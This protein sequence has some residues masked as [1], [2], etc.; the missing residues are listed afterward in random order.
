MM[1]N[2]IQANVNLLGFNLLSTEQYQFYAYAPSNNYTIGDDQDLNIVWYK[3]EAFSQN[4]KAEIIE[5]FTVTKK[6]FTNSNNQYDHNQFTITGTVKIETASKQA[7]EARFP[8]PLSG[9]SQDKGYVHWLFLGDQFEEDQKMFL[10]IG[11]FKPTQKTGL[12]VFPIHLDPHN[13]Y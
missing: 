2:S 10:G 7:K 8:V 5:P 1:E 9:V 11:F 4:F 3:E 12:S 13:I 6:E